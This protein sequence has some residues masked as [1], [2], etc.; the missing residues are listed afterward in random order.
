MELQ[1]SR[2][3]ALAP[4]TYT[5]SSFLPP[6][7][8]AVDGP[9]YSFQLLPGFFDIQQDVGSPDVIAVQF[10]KPDAL[11][12]KDGSAVPLVDI[13]GAASIL[14]ANP[15]LTLLESHVT[16]IGGLDGEILIVE[17]DGTGGAPVMR[18][19]PGPLSILP[20]R[21]LEINLFTT[22]DGI[23]AILVGGSIAKWNEAAAAAQP[24]LDS[25][26]IGS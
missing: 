17:N 13:A 25:I 6:I 18:T 1:A 22:P 9:W 2:T 7:T 4:G 12:G 26:K 10:T 16:Q 20:G 23:L 21:R 5:R 24:V 3:V 8:F 14:M 15:G 11:Y 19:L